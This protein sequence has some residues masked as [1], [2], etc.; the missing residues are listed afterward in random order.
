[1]PKTKE[2]NEIIKSKRRQEIV[3][4]GLKLF[5]TKGYDNVTIN[6]ITLTTGCSHGLFYHYFTSKADLLKVII[7]DI[8]STTDELFN[9]FIKTNQSPKQFFESVIRSVFIKLN[10]PRNLQ[11]AYRIHIWF[12]LHLQKTAPVMKKQK[13]G[14]LYETPYDFILQC[15]EKGQLAGEFKNDH[16]ATE[17]TI[18][19]FGFLQSLVTNR[20]NMNFRRF[21]VP[22]PETFIGIFVKL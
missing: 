19:G 12:T 8:K 13:G 2:Q 16:P 10:N 11:F 17:Y 4:T 18:I 14:A 1:M 5:A 20:I 7:T 9:Q 6:D 21:K 22:S 3:Q 15:I